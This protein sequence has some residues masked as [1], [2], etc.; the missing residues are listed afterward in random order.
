[1]SL[2]RLSGQIGL[3]GVGGGTRG[4]DSWVLCDTVGGF[5]LVKM[6]V[7]VRLDLI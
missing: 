7:G 1:M 4:G 2:W 6:V 3:G 5:L